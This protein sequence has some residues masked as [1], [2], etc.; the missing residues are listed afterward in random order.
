MG[1][2]TSMPKGKRVFLVCRSKNCDE[3]KKS[4][5]RCTI[6][7]PETAPDTTLNDYA[8]ALNRRKLCI[9]YSAE[10]IVALSNTP[11]WHISSDKPGRR[12]LIQQAQ[13]NEQKVYTD[14]PDFLEL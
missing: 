12:K 11:N 4:G 5:V 3:A 7:R 10:V 1:G 9:L 13:E 6:S 2:A 8:N 14:N